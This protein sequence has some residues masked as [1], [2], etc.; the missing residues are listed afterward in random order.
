MKTENVKRLELALGLQRK[1]VGVKFLYNWAEYQDAGGEPYDKNTRFCVMV[2]R[3]SDYA[4]S[5]IAAPDEPFAGSCPRMEAYEEGGAD[6]RWEDI[7]ERGVCRLDGV[8]AG[9]PVSVAKRLRQGGGGA[10]LRDARL[11]A[12]QGGNS[13]AG[14][15]VRRG[16]SDERP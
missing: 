15:G 14:G 4:W 8:C 16:R 11:A 1:I 7:R 2:K 12:R 13:G 9:G 10:R 6:R 3:A 5:W